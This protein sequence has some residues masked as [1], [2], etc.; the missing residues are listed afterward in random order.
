MRSATPTPSAVGAAGHRPQRWSRHWKDPHLGEGALLAALRRRRR[1]RAGLTQLVYTLA[2]AALGIVVPLLSSGPMVR[3]TTV[4]PLLYGM[5]GGLISFI[6]LVFSL[7]FLVV[8]FGNTTVSPRLTLFRDDPLVWHSFGFFTAVFV[9]CTTAGVRVGSPQGEVTVA[10]PVVAVLLV[11]VALGLSRAV[12]M[13]ALKLLQLNATMEEVRARGEAVLARFYRAPADEER[14]RRSLPPRVEEVVWDRPTTTLEQVDLPRLI[15]EAERLDA[16]IEIRVRIG[17]EVRRGFPVVAI[18]A[19][20]PVAD[21]D[22]L[23]AFATGIDRSFAQDPFL[24]FRLLSDIANRALSAAVNDPATGVQAVGCIHD[25]LTVVV[26]RRLDFGPIDGRDGTPRVQLTFPTWE[27]FV[28]AGVD[29]VAHY[30]DGAPTVRQRVVTMLE[31]L[32]ARAPVDRRAP[33]EARLARLA[34]LAPS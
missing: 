30:C 8:Q 31:D 32:A 25:L 15:S 22:V 11:I 4:R 19:D 20:H 2:G 5:A 26:D 28:A 14:P 23:R 7:L 12:Q 16:A 10:V 24:A 29:E 6:A 17:D 13:R 34:Q 18:H 21:H 1:L 33:L 9:F 27:D 3:D